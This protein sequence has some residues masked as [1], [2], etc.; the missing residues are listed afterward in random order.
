MGPWFLLRRV[1]YI[2]GCVY[3]IFS[4][5]LFEFETFNAILTSVVSFQWP[6]HEYLS[7]DDFVAFVVKANM[8]S[9]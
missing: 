2:K 7:K 8:P 9:Y 3:N 6:T 5:E 1:E 4:I